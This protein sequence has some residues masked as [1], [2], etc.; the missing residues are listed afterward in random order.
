MIADNTYAKWENDYPKTVAIFCN[1]GAF[2]FS[3]NKKVDLSSM[4]RYLSERLLNELK[5]DELKE[6]AKLYRINTV[7]KK[8]TDLIEELKVLV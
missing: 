6:Y 3:I 1:N 4:K 2:D 5:V 8:K 7:D